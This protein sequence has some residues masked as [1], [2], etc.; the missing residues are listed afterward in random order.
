MKW[1]LSAELIGLLVVLSAAVIQLCLEHFWRGRPEKH[2]RRWVYVLTVLVIVGAIANKFGDWQTREEER[3]ERERIERTTKER[4]LLAQRERQEISTNIQDLVTLARERDPGLTELE[5]VRMITTEVRTLRGRTSQLEHEL[6]G[7]RRYSKVAKYNALGLTGIAGVGLKE[8]SP[9]ARA[10]EG[11]Y[12]NTEGEAS[13]QYF[14]R[15]DAQGLTRF[16]HVARK[17]PDFPFSHWALAKCL[18]QA[19]NPQWR[20]HAVRA[21]TIFEHT[22]RISER[23]QH[24]DEA[25]KQIE[26]LLTE[27]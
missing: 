14:P 15:C 5:A 20:T 17:F 2:R 24:H 27:Q 13:A 16:A 19:G 21:I 23:N 1:E 3:E 9:I 8:N 6:Q 26:Q 7:L 25:R 11:A 4:E 22:T 18:K 10:L 12:I